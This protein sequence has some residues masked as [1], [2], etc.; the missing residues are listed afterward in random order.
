MSFHW[1]FSS[2]N[3]GIKSLKNLKKRGE[4][5]GSRAKFASSKSRI[6]ARFFHQIN[7]KVRKILLAGDSS[8]NQETFST[9]RILRDLL[10]RDPNR[11][12]DLLDA[13]SF[14]KKKS[15]VKS[16]IVSARKDRSER[17]ER[18]EIEPRILN[19]DLQTLARACLLLSAL[20]ISLHYHGDRLATG[21][22]RYRPHRRHRQPELV[23]KLATAAAGR[24]GPVAVAAILPAQ[25]RQSIERDRV[26]VRTIA[27]RSLRD[28]H[29]R[30]RQALE[31]DDDRL[32]RQRRQL[33]QRRADTRVGP[34]VA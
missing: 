34:D 33:L 32:H 24:G 31:R 28:R 17:T 27:S 29:R 7:I 30:A 6:V 3:K 13:A 15:S 26:D 8:S 5:G 16:E 4:S 18:G 25:N 10:A 19:K 1:R 21:L 22:G 11:D 14:A 23:P 20:A 2:K 9:T 12:Q